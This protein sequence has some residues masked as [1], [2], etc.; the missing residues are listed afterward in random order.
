MQGLIKGLPGGGLL[1]M[2]ACFLNVQQTFFRIRFSEFLITDER[3]QCVSPF[4]CMGRKHHKLG[5]LGVV[6]VDDL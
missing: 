1:R 4:V 6:R 3:R 2:H 5:V